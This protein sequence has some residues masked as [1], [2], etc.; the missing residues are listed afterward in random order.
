MVVRPQDRQQRLSKSLPAPTLFGVGKVSLYIYKYVVGNRHTIP[1]VVLL[2]H[3][4]GTIVST[5]TV[6]VN[7]F[8]DTVND[9]TEILLD[10]AR[11]LLRAEAEIAVAKEELH[12]AITERKF[13]VDGV[14]FQL[15]KDSKTT[16]LPVI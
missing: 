4:K 6:D 2:V 9:K 14:L 11:A 8:A 3:R 5:L 16:G 1:C 10:A 7:V 13:F 12:K 15:V